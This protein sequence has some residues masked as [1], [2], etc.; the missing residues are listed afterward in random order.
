MQLAQSYIQLSI[1][2]NTYPLINP[3][4]S[5]TTNQGKTIYTKPATRFT[6]QIPDG[7]ADMIRQILATSLY[8]PE[9]WRRLHD[10][11]PL[12][13]IALKTGTSDIKAGKTAYPRDGLSIIYSPTDLIITRAGNTDGHPMG[14]KAFGGEI[15]HAT[16][17]TY[18]DTALR[19]DKI[20]DQPRISNPNVTT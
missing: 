8:M 15:N 14:P 9:N 10:K 12:Q 2:G 18:L 11:L 13:H 19:L 16:L 1:T 4:L 5:I 20:V 3:I 7:V 17:K 6:K